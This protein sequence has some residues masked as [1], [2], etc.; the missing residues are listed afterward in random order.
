[1]HKTAKDGGDTIACQGKVKGIGDILVG[2]RIVCGKE[3]RQA[4]LYLC[5][6]RVEHL[7]VGRLIHLEVAHVAQEFAVWTEQDIVHVH[8]VSVI[9]CPFLIAGLLHLDAP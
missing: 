8:V 2:G 3:L 4:R 6:L 7:P 9:V 5:V 1:M